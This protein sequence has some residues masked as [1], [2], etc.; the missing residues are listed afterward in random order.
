MRSEQR[1][2]IFH[3]SICLKYFLSSSTL[4]SSCLEKG[5]IVKAGNGGHT[6]YVN[7]IS[8][9]GILFV[10]HMTRPLLIGMIEQFPRKEGFET[11]GL[12]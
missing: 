7:M 1:S 6:G 8:E 3:D 2:A 10:Y 9:Y 4:S 12:F 11:S 5:C